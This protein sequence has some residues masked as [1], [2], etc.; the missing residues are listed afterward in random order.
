MLAIRLTGAV[1]L[2]LAAIWM[3]AP[4]AWAESSSP[5]PIVVGT[6]NN[7]GTVTTTVTSPGSDGSHTAEPVSSGG[8]S[9]IRCTYYYPG[10][11][12]QL[13]QEDK[14]GVPGRYYFVDCSRGTQPVSHDLIWFA[15]S[16]PPPGVPVVVTPAELAQ[17]AVDQ[18]PLP[19][20]QARHNPDRMDGRPQTVVGIAT[21]WWVGAASFRSITHT[22]QAGPVWATVTARP[23]ST[24]WR[25][26]SA[27]A[28]DVRCAGA[29]TAYDPSRPADEQHTDCFTVYQR[30]SASQPQ[31]GPDPNDRFFTATVTVAW[32]VT[33]VGAG[34]AS[35]ALPPL[36]RTSTFPI[37]VAEVQTV[38]E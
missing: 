10:D 2:S 3:P 19:T 29:G 7:G 23:V 6:D 14:N 15:D 22:V 30:S 9:A 26:G 16:A 31:T 21:W 27:H 8:G 35:G 28:D 38:N 4:T 33:W 12:G 24:F 32:Q 5:G 25:S 17:Q 34:G 1:L 18:L 11:D 37:A 20:P 36:T 13:Y